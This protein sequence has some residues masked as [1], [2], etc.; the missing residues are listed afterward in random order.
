MKILNFEGWNLLNESFRFGSSDSGDIS[1]EL[2][3][4]GWD[5][6]RTGSGDWE[7]AKY[8]SS[9][10]EGGRTVR[11][12]IKKGVSDTIEARVI[13]QETGG[14]IDSADIRVE[15]LSAG[16]LDTEIWKSLALD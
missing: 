10:D 16:E 2:A 1:I 8:F 11:L 5:I 14:V 15:G 4:A 7:A 3:E 9:R 6:S 12:I 13:N